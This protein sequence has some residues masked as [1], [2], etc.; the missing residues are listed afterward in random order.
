[1]LALG[2]L[3][4]YRVTRRITALVPAIGPLSR[5]VVL[6]VGAVG[7][8]VLAG[9]WVVLTK[10]DYRALDLGSLVVP[11]LL[12][13]FALGDRD[14]RV[15]SARR[16]ARAD[17]DARRTRCRRAGARAR[18][19]D[20]RAAR[21]A[22]RRDAHRRDRAVV[23]RQANDPRAAQAVDHDHDG[24]SAFFGGPDCNDNDPTST[25]ARRTSL[26]TGS[27]RTAS[28]ATPISRTTPSTP[29]RTL[30]DEL[31]RSAAHRPASAERSQN[32]L[33]IFVDTLRLRPARLHR[34]SARRQVA[35]AAARRVREAVSRVQHAYAQASNTPRSVPSFL[36]SR[37]PSQVKGLDTT[38][39][40][41]ATMA[42]TTTRSSRCS[43]RPGSPTIGESSSTSTSATT[44]SP[45]TPAAM[46]STRWQADA[47]S[48]SGRR[49][50]G[51]RRRAQGI[52]DSNHDSA[53]PRIVEEDAR[54]ARRAR[55][56]SDIPSGRFAM[57]VHLFDPHSTY[58]EHAGSQ[59]HRARRRRL[60]QKYDYEIAFEDGLIG[61]CSTRS[62]PPG[63][64]RPR[65]SS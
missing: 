21:H 16:G 46:S 15:R 6:V 2:A 41:Y 10:L 22:V 52:P 63:S 49:P 23:S 34:L 38:F 37:Y 14:P 62:T 33:V 3:P 39:K 54:Q 47:T 40:D 36:T 32:V 4:I 64:P 17:P 13:V 59:V 55:Q 25:P 45:R 35:D 56:A 51:Q 12:P 27:T 28:A 29:I 1:M 11:A 50:V 5:V 7:A 57:I 26:T 44:R 53:G 43:S 65:R 31:G 58:M 20:R 42:T 60:V 18:A 9:A 61:D 19:A 30:A 48:R 24:Y 8:L